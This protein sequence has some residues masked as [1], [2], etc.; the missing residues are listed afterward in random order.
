MQLNLGGLERRKEKE[1]EIFNIYKL[2]KSG[3]RANQNIPKFKLNGI[4]DP[5]KAK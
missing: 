3:S 1:K 2:T 4:A 5:I